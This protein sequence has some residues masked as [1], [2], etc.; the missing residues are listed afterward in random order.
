MM[1]PPDFH[2]V[3]QDIAALATA[4]GVFFAARQLYLAKGQAQSQFEDSLNGQYRVLLRELP[5]NALLGKR[6]SEEALQES[7]SAFFRYFDL[8]NEQAFL[9]STGRIRDATW[10]NW[11][12]G[13]QQNM[14]RPAFQQAWKR[15]LPDLDGSF[16]ELKRLEGTRQERVTQQ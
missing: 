6:L 9:R 12:E 3:L 4:L 14:G 10:S 5:L 11:E 7:L 13:I 8:S 2:T 15:M 16:D 1:L